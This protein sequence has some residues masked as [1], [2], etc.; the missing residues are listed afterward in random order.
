MSKVFSRAFLAAAL[1]S[2]FVMSPAWAKPAP[3]PAAVA[4][5]TSAVAEWSQKVWDRA[6]MGG[7]AD[8]LELVAGAPNLDTPEMAAFRASIDRYKANI[9]KREEARATRLEQLRKDL[10]EAREKG[11]QKKSL[12]AA[13][14]IHTLS[15]DKAAFLDTPEIKE[16]VDQALAAA[17]E[18]EA[19]GRWLDAH[20]SF[21]YLN[22]LFDE[23]R[24]YEP[25]LKRL[26]QR[27]I[28]LRLYIPERLHAIRNQQRIA[29]GEKELPPF[30]KVGENWRDKLVGIDRAMVIRAIGSASEMNVER[31][32][33]GQML[34]GAFNAL[35]VMATTTDL[36]EPFPTLNDPAKRDEFM[37]FIDQNLTRFREAPDKAALTDLINS[38]DK[39][40]AVNA[41]TVQIGESALLHEFG[42]G[43]IGEL[44]EFTSII[45]PDELANF[46]RTTEGKF[47]GVGIQIQ[48][49][50]A[51]DLKV[52]TPLDGT[53]AQRA[54]IRPGDLIRKIDGESTLGI[55]LP[56]A[57]DRI[58]GKP[59]TPVVLTIEREGCADPLD[60]PLVRQDIPL[61]SVKG[62]ERNGPHETDWG[63]FIDDEHRIGYLRLTQFTK[64]TTSEMRRAIDEMRVAGLRG[65]IMDLRFN[66]G[67]LLQEAVGVVSL[68]AESGKVVTQEDAEGR[69]I[70]RQTIRPGNDAILGDLPVVV[71]INGGSASASE[72]V[73]G[74]LQDYHKAV[75]LGDRS[76]GKG[77]VQQVFGL[78]PR[79]A[80]KLTTQFYRLPEGRLIHR[81]PGCEKWGVEP[82]V[83]VEMLPKQMGDA[84]VLRQE[85][86]IARFDENGKKIEDP[87]APDETKLLTEGLDPQ[88]EAALMLVQSQVVGTPIRQARTNEN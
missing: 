54:G 72:I 85:A 78:S 24:T 51:L 73:S 19:A 39:L 40:L 21:N 53:P 34:V 69:E 5:E 17:R 6:L 58:T 68:F 35:H 29:E 2:A 74:A 11:D 76:F 28:M 16:L 12:R 8:P 41:R 84:L 75:I 56:Q 3:Q 66:P 32:Q 7:V 23:Q 64:D 49:N 77:S 63:W 10:A 50:D 61:Y 36:A 70:E 86:D 22:M 59:G 14:E 45:W 48:L 47:I 20:D 71:L 30:N 52:V 88:L 57:V 33:L 31:V 13:I 43:A 44:D 38:V 67:G 87:A 27:L 83:T 37:A 62:W 81:R 1:A 65:I 60:F 55:S 26:G 80:F 25:D 15:K 4:A 79:A 9:V 46:Q 42:N 18:H 82:D